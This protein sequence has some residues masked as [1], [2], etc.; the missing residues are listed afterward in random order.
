LCNQKKRG[1]RRKTIQTSKNGLDT[2]AKQKR[3][4]TTDCGEHTTHTAEDL[5]NVENQ[6]ILEFLLEE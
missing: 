5:E 4:G 6:A 3:K 2:S 1:G